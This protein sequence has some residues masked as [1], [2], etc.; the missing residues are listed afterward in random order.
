MDWTEI[1]KIFGSAALGALGAFVV[2]EFW[3]LMAAL[4]GVVA[5]AWADRKKRRL[6]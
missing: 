4:L 1:F 3:R 5:E 6:R 2:I